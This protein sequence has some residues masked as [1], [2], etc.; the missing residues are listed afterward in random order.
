MR[1]TKVPLILVA[2]AV[3]ALAGCGHKSNVTTQS[4]GASSADSS[5]AVVVAAGTR[6]YGKL[7]QPIDTKT[8][9]DGDTFALDQTDTLFHKDPA[10]H[11]AVVEGHLE[12]VRSA[13]MA[14]KPALE[15]VFDD[16]RMPDGTKAPINVKLLSF[17]AFEPKTHHLRTLAMMT[18]GAIAGHEIAKHSGK[19]HGGLVGAAGG[20]VLSQEMKTDIHVPAGTVIELQ[21]L[22]P[23]RASTN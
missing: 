18:G 10:L 1:F 15:L 17:K 23:A 3:F 13:G 20:Y 12:G 21:F 8:S 11:G 19:K 6:Y 22:S 14:R 7:E 5:G 16:I 9:R 2:G 4:A